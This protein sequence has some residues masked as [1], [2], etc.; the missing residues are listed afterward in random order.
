M[1]PNLEALIQQDQ[2]GVDPAAR[3][4]GDDDFLD[5]DNFSL[6]ALAKDK[7][8]VTVRARYEM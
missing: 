7:H 4:R 5:P 1:Y 2:E 8:M 3:R 6:K